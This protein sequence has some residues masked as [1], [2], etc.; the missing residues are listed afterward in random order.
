[1]WAPNKWELPF[2]SEFLT[3]FVYH[4]PALLVCS[5][6]AGGRWIKNEVREIVSTFFAKLH[7][8]YWRKSCV[9]KKR[10]NTNT[11]IS[12]TNAWFNCSSNLKIIVIL[13]LLKIFCLFKITK[14]LESLQAG[15]EQMTRFFRQVSVCKVLI[16]KQGPGLHYPILSPQVVFEVIAAAC[17]CC[18]V[19]RI[20][21]Y[22][23]TQRGALPL[24]AYVSSKAFVS[25]TLRWHTSAVW[26][27]SGLSSLG[28][29]V[30]LVLIGL[31]VLPNLWVLICSPSRME[32]HF[33]HFKILKNKKFW[34]E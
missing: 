33:V 18:L 7:F 34:R 13:W 25:S 29:G 15:K 30:F 2:F 28:Q 3:Q 4:K 31:R 21:L 23:Q 26:L 27:S 16:Q 17:R 1:M 11:S 5:L 12:I 24:I 10:I 9:R 32:H 8:F 22:T 20:S 6:F 14:G 19:Q